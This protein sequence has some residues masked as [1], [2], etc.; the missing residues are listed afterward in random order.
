MTQTI[1]QKSV[2]PLKKILPRSIWS[3]LRAF[4][5]AMMTPVRFSTKTG[6]WKSSLKMS[7]VGTDGSPTPWYTY[8]ALDFLSQRDFT[9]R[10]VLE[11]GGGQSTLWWSKRAQSVLTVEENA[12]W[13]ASLR[14]RRVG[15]NVSLHHVPA[16]LDT[17]SIAAVKA[18]LDASPVTKFDVIIVDG[19][20]RKE[21]TGLAFD[22]LA[23]GGAI[24]IDNAEGYEIHD[25][26]RHK[27]CRRI[28][29]FGFAPG[30]VLRHCT[31]LVFCGDCFL[32]SP[33]I[34]IAD[35]ENTIL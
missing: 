29:F 24:V 8:P 30:V 11:F 2:A 13:F 16:D 9:C 18:V 33:D 15:G 32:L 27:N 28:D 19:H 22:Y 10:Q 14:R 4:A 3:P 7:A 17:R 12:D 1:L 23:P 26:L 25:V 31:S 35:I 20:L 21:L 6:H 5:T 34:P